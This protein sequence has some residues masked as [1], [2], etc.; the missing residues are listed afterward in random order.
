MPNIYN[1]HFNNLSSNSGSVPAIGTMQ[2]S[3]DCR[4]WSYRAAAGYTISCVCSPGG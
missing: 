3:T 1:S 2:N 4:G